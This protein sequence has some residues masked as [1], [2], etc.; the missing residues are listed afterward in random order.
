MEDSIGIN[1]KELKTKPGAD[2]LAKLINNGTPG[3]STKKIPLWLV[4]LDNV[5]TLTMFILGALIINQ[6]STIWAVVFM[7]YALFSVVYFW[8]RICPFCHHYASQAC[9]CGYGVISA[10]FFKK[11]TDKPFIRVFKNN[12]GIVFPNWFVPTGVAI[13]LFITQYNQ[14]LLWL[15]IAFALIGY[16]IIP[17]I[18]KF[19]GCKSCD[20]KDECPWMQ[21]KNKIKD[22]MARNGT[23]VDGKK[24][25][26]PEMEEQVG[27]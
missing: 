7:A 14:T 12:L 11:R 25:I 8:A 6:I 24:I 2:Q 20:I 1:N 3:C 10:K 16:V 18:S 26:I 5:P 27:C 15:S 22:Q 19:V 21:A 13:Y 23:T 4:L 9:P 17:L